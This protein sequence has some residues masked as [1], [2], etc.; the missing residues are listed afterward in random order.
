MPS[1]DR[2]V[3][4]ERLDRLLSEVEAIEARLPESFERFAAA[5]DEGLRY[6]LEHRLLIAIQSM[7]DV[8]T[9]IAVVTGARPLETYRDGVV[10]LPGIG[11]LSHES[12]NELAWCAG[13]R[14][15]LVHE[16]AGVDQA[17]VYEALREVDVLAEFAGAVWEWVGK[18]EDR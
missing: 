4:R 13:M 18:R 12:A 10:A 6:E 14:N 3:V 17:R 11:V 5:A 9:H 15:V 7:L 16:Y 8:A 2:E 1:V